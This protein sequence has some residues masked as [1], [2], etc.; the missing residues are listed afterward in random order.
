MP[1]QAT[2]RLTKATCWRGRRFDQ[3]GKTHLVPGNSPWALCGAEPG[4]EYG[5]DWTTGEPNGGAEP[6]IKCERAATKGTGAAVATAA[7]LD[8]SLRHRSLDRVRCT[9]AGPM[10]TV[11]C[12]SAGWAMELTP[13]QAEGLLGRLDGVADLEPDQVLE[14]VR[15]VGGRVKA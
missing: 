2:Q 12:G 11:R 14:Y 13:D 10:V 8:L 9:P 6:C 4:R 5:G 1:R 7:M 15:G 3:A